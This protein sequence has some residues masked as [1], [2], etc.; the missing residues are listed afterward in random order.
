MADKEESISKIDRPLERAIVGGAA[1]RRF[2]AG[3]RNLFASAAVR[4]DRGKIRDR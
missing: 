3:I 1:R 4:S 2:T